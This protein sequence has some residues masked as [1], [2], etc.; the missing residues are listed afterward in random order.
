MYKI[1][2][3]NYEDNKNILVLPEGIES[4]CKNV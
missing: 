3:H 4:E 1:K 2:K